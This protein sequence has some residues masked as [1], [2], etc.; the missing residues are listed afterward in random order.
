MIL[1]P[2]VFFV[3]RSRMEKLFCG[4]RMPS[5]DQLECVT[6]LFCS[7]LFV[8]DDLMYSDWSPDRLVSEQN[9]FSRELV[10]D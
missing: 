5:G 6:S 9:N 3:L 4:H 8:L 7:V 1:Q 10:A 2:E